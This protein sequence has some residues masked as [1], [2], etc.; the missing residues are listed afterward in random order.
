MASDAWVSAHLLGMA[1]FVLLTVG[2]MALVLA[3]RRSAGRSLAVSAGMA[4]LGTALVLP[5]YGAETFGLHVIGGLALTR[6]SMSFVETVD[7]VRLDPVALTMFGGGLVALATS[8]AFLPV[9]LWRSGALARAGALVLG[10]GLLLYLPQF[11]GSPALR[12]SHGVLMTVGCV[13]LAWAILRGSLR[14]QAPRPARA[15]T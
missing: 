12:V 6:Q 15:R 2:L 8:G 4:W 11:Y 5:Y 1:A 3:H 10:A 14:D 7:A 13:V 9:A